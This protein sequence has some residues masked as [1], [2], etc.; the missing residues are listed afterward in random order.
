M[1]RFLHGADEPASAHGK[2]TLFR[3]IIDAG[4]MFQDTSWQTAFGQ[5]RTMTGQF[6]WRS[7]IPTLA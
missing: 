7:K 2:I 6:I 4:L 3:N 1:C 5:G